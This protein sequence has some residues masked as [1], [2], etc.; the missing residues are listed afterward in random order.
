V[1]ERLQLPPPVI[2]RAR[3]LLDDGARRVSD[4]ILKLEEE[5]HAAEQERA[6]LA[7][8][9]A[10]ATAAAKTAKKA[11]EAAALRYKEI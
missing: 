7:A 4:L 6:A 8:Q 2:H 1:A 3:D 9:Q 10:E 11:E 5:T